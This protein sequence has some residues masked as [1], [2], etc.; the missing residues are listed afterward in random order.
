[1]VIN[2]K[3]IATTAL[4]LGVLASITLSDKVLD[5]AS[6]NFANSHTASAL[7]ISDKDITFVPDISKGVDIDIDSDV[8][9]A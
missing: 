7:G 2:K 8:D 3:A 1:M 9:G 4:T 6:G 5:I